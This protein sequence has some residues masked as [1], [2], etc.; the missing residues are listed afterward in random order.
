MDLT[1][2]LVKEYFADVNTND[3]TISRFCSTGYLRTSSSL[4]QILSSQVTSLFLSIELKT[5]FIGFFRFYA[6]EI[7]ERRKRIKHPVLLSE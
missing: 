3:L 4:G 2:F 7:Q 6:P 1:V 5:R